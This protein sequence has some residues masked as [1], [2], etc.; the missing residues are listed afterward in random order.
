MMS[1]LLL[2][3]QYR[4][5]TK[6]LVLMWMEKEK[7]PNFELKDLNGKALILVKL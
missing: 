1:M 7:V 6:N 4:C 3:V 2:F 5:G